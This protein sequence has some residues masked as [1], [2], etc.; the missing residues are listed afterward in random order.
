[1]KKRER[2]GECIYSKRRG[3]EWEEERIRERM[4]ERR[5]GN[6]DTEIWE[7]VLWRGRE[8]EFER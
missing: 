2:E 1:M 4:R 3:R 6:G 5:K 8:R 7:R